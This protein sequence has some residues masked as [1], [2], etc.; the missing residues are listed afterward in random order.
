MHDLEAPTLPRPLQRDPRV[1]GAVVVVG[2]PHRVAQAEQAA[3]RGEVGGAEAR[4][5]RAVPRARA[6]VPERHLG[7]LPALAQ[8][9]DEDLRQDVEAVRLERLDIQQHAAAI[10][11]EATGDVLVRDRQE[12]P[13][14]PVEH[15][16]R[17]PAP[18]PHLRDRPTHVPGPDHDLGALTVRPHHLHEVRHVG[19]VGVDREDELAARGRQP[20]LQDVP[21]AAELRREIHGVGLRDQLLHRLVEAVAAHQDLGRDVDAV[22]RRP[23]R[24]QHACEVVSLAPHGDHDRQHEVCF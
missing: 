9:L 23:Q 7:H 18:E 11:A 19:E 16:A 5:P 22:D 4:H 3:E 8:R 1:E 10:Q 17:E 12:E 6:P 24:G 15:P 14:D 2:G 13:I 21:V 20:R